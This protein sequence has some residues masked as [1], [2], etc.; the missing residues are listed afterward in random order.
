MVGELLSYVQSD[1]VELKIQRFNPKQALEDLAELVIHEVQDHRTVHVEVKLPSGI[2]V[3]ADQRLML[4][5]VENLLRNAIQHANANVLLEVTSEEGQFGVAVHD[6]GPGI[7]EEL[8]DKVMA[9]FYRLQA[10]RG[11]NTGGV[12][13]GLAIVARITQ[14]HGGHVTLTD[15]PLGGAKVEIVWPQA[16]N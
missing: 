14:R 7:P 11:R 12:G 1:D 16:F 4:R 5:A 13:L 10:D 3:L 8:R 2:H 6:D 9:P 15:S